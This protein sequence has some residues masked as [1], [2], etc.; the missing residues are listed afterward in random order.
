MSAFV[1]SVIN[2][3]AL[4]MA[5]ALIAVGYSLVFGI[6]RLINFAHGS[7]YAF[8]AYMVFLFV[9]LK[10]GFL[11]AIIVSVILSGLL[12]FLMD[13]VTLEPLRK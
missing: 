7:I 5:Y 11:P 1:G 13:K 2:G 4:G 3:I 12:A 6:L 10:L 8:G 9:T